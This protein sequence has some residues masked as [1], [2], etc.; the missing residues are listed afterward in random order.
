[1]LANLLHTLHMYEHMLANDFK[2]TTT[3]WAHVN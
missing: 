1:M 3:V 2:L